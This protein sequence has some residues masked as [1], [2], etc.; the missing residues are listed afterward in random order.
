VTSSH[1]PLEN[2][3]L[4][5]LDLRALWETLRLRWWVIPITPL[6]VVGFLWA[7]E[8]DLRKEPA[9]YTVSRTY[10]GR[11]PTGVLAS[12]GIDPVSVRSFP[13]ANNQ[14]LVLQSAA[15]RDEIA[16]QIGTSATVNILRSRPSFTLIDTLESD[17]ESSFVFQSA[18]VPT[19]SFSCNAPERGTCEAAIDAYV[20]KA[21]TLRTDAL[22]AGL[23]ELKAVL[24]EVNEQSNDPTLAA[25]IIALDVLINRADTPLAQISEYEQV[26]GATVSSISRRTYTFGGAVGLFFSLLILLQ[27]SVSDGRIRTL[28]QLIR[29]VGSER[30]LGE[31]VTQPDE[32]HDRRIAVGLR[33]GLNRNHCTTVRFLTLRSLPAEHGAIGRVIEQSRI[34]SATTEVLTKLSVTDL[35]DSPGALDILV[36]QR[37]RDTRKDVENALSTLKY[38]AQVLG[39][40]VLSSS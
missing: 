12:V 39:G 37:D 34:T 29:L 24:E 38:S 1:N 22:R 23:G 20:A 8:T 40:V 9:S 16:N 7:Q 5:G 35:M 28:R 32:L 15:V 21:S 10:E 25:K 27:L 33:H 6:A 17:G 30:V 13:D 26:I 3:L 2:G 4:T 18:G 11:D 31:L 19:Y 36:V 14:L